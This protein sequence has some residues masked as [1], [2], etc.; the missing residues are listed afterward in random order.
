MV[1]RSWRMLVDAS[2]SDATERLL[3]V[4]T[5]IK[6]R[7]GEPVAIELADDMV[8]EFAASPS[9]R[10]IGWFGYRHMLEAL[11]RGAALPI[12][13][14]QYEGDP[15]YRSMVLTRQEL[16]DRR[17]PD[18]GRGRRLWVGA[19]TM[20]AGWLAPVAALREQGIDAESF[21]DVVEASPLDQGVLAVARGDGDYA[22]TYNRA[23]RKLIDRGEL[24]SSDFAIAW[25]SEPLPYDALVV[26][27]ELDVKTRE[28]LRAAVLSVGSAEEI[29][30]M[31]LGYTGFS[32]AAAHDYEPVRRITESKA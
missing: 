18:D 25:A 19:R 6:E 8:G 12:A 13:M 21:F 15:F 4:A 30:R 20:L 7:L 2:V 32:Y 24:Q 29:A 9:R 10:L 31:P 3:P 27:P 16:A 22:A 28:R 5:M 1:S 23:L 14:V 17:W 11:R 26:G